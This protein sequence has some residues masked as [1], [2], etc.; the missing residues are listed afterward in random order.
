MRTFISPCKT[1]QL[2]IALPAVDLLGRQAE[3]AVLAPQL[4]G[5]AAAIVVLG[6]GRLGEYRVARRCR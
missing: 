2:A 3:L 1:C 6:E 4:E 5:R